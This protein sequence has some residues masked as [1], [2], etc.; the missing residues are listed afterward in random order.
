[1]FSFTPDEKEL[2]HTAVVC[3]IHTLRKQPWPVVSE[4]VTTLEEIR[5]T[6]G[7]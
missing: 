3:H 5:L 7:D 6:L 2:L 1:M 4:D